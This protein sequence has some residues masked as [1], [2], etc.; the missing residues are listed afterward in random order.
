LEKEFDYAYDLAIHFMGT[1]KAC[2]KIGFN[3]MEFPFVLVGAF[4]LHVLAPLVIFVFPDSSNDTYSFG[5]LD[6]G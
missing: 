6:L 5:L 3:G 4:V 1:S 2:L